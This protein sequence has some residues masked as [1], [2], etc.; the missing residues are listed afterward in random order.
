MTTA[1]A[2]AAPKV[3]LG[4]VSA[5]KNPLP[6]RVMTYGVDGI[7]KTT[8]WSEA[9]K[10][11]FICTEEGAT[12]VEVA[13][14]PLCESWGSLMDCLRAL[15]MEDHDYQT[16]V[17][18]SAD[19]AQ[20][21]LVAHIT[22]RDFG[23][24]PVAFDNYG[25]GWRPTMA[26]WIKFLAALDV[27][28]RRKNMEIALIAHAV[29]STFK[30]PEGDDYNI[31]KSNLHDSEKTSVWARTKEWCDLVLFMNYRVTV[32]DA[33]GAKDGPKKGKGVMVK[34]EQARLVHAQKNAAWEAKVRAGWEMPASFPL[35]QAEF[36]NHINGKDAK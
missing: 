14:F 3:T 13:K 10:P 21:L 33:E 2:P 20:S 34:G 11:I 31:Y 12:R 19:W 15:V 5:A 36:R 29:V 23:G 7:G 4:D 30:N 35:S 28:R 16:V 8:F 9:P 6:A 26:E 27:V 25:R 18:D 17:I 22:E 32:R 24:D 1:I